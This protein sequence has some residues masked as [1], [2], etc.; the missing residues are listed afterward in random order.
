VRNPNKEPHTFFVLDPLLIVNDYKVGVSY[1]INRNL[2][3][4]SIGSLQTAALEADQAFTQQM[5]DNNNGYAIRMK[6]AKS[7]LG[8]DANYTYTGHRFVN[9]I[10]ADAFVASYVNAKIAFVNEFTF[11]SVCI[12]FLVYFSFFSFVFN[13][14]IFNVCFLIDFDFDYFFCSEK[15][16]NISFMIDGNVQIN[17]PLRLIT[18]TA[19]G[20]NV[21]V[22]SFLFNFQFL[23]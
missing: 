8:L 1:G 2:G 16:K 22:F 14:I 6:S 10:P 17:V 12:F 15:I 7:L 4:C 23:I 18:R 11:S 3:N 5:I 21:L 9:Q 19:N 20:S 13:S